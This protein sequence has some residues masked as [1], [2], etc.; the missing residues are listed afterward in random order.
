VKSECLPFGQVPHTSKLFADYLSW[1]PQVHP[2]YARPAHYRQWI[3]DETSAIRYDNV[4]RAQMAAILER[5]NKAWGSS[6][7]TLENIQRFRAGAVASVTGQQVGLFCGPLFSMFKA[8]TAVKIAEETTQ[9]GADCIPVFWLATQ[10][11]DLAEVNH[12]Q[13][14]GQDAALETI[15]IPTH[16]VE[17]APV[18]TIHFGPEI[19]ALVEA[20]AQA[21]GDCETAD[22]LRSSYKSGETFGS[23]YARFFA[24]VFAD[25]G[26]V[27]F[28]AS[29]PEV[30]AIAA[31][32]F[33]A[34]IE[35]SV[36]IE[37]AL[38]ERGKELEAT[39]YHQQVKVTPNATLLFGTQNGAR[40]PI[41]RTSDSEFLIGKE[42]ISPADLLR[43]IAS[44]SQEFS[45]NVLLRPVVQDYLLP[46]L[47]YNGGPAEVAYFAQGSAVYK[48][49]AG[50]VTPII[51][52]FSATLIE[53]RLKALLEK[54]SLHVRS[55]FAGPDAV[56]EQLAAHVLPQDFHQT[57][58]RASESV[59]SALDAVR[60]VLARVDK[61]LVDSA[62]NAGEKMHYQLDQLRSKAARAELRQTE[63]L[64]RHAELLS[65]AL[66]PNKTLQE[67][68]ISALY[69]VARH[70]H[71]LLRDVYSCIQPDCLDHQL[72]SLDVQ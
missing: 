46:T 71:Q 19:D 64:G 45:A 63:V 52:R 21:L 54:Y 9:A 65:N 1:S 32:V 57:F 58:D 23:A 7:K 3:K 39:G 66:Y 55:L 12:I 36:E 25:W 43:R 53:P 68:E 17:D 10:D 8:L 14:M 6:A 47:A 4:R 11:H 37:K 18:G 51:P 67:R 42:K 20:T 2:F 28:D 48:L 50:R 29:D 41:H 38:M 72:I 35:R 26:I 60:E 49:L 59:A 33:Q 16:G 24:R 31:P 5:Q 40:T 27:L 34:A 22:W 15:S 70:G 44:A 13:M 30:T 62:K 61:T 69:F 56:R